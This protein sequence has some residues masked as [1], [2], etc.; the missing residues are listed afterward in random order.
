MV[1]GLCR[2]LLRNTDDAEDATQQVFV[3]AQR[4][5]LSG[6]VPREPPAWLAAIARNECRARIRSRMRE[7]LT[8]QELPNDLPDPLASALYADDLDAFWEAL[9][10]LPRRQRKAFL[11]RELGGLSYGELGVALGVTRPAVESLLFRARQGLRSFIAATNA[12]LI[13]VGLRDQLSRF[14]PE[15]GAA[16]GAGGVPLA[17]KVAAVTVGAGIGAAGVLELPKKAHHARPDQA[18]AP[19]V[20]HARQPA[21]ASSPSSS[22]AASSVAVKPRRARDTSAAKGSKLALDAEH[23]ARR[24]HGKGRRGNAEHVQETSFPASAPPGQWHSQSSNSSGKHLGWAKTKHAGGASDTGAAPGNSGGDAG[25]N[26]NGNGR[27]HG[28]GSD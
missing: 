23:V 4:A 28:N 1:L 12:A 17:A 19:R 9:S 8:T 14:L 16:A 22:A 3:S 6:A 5:V 13:P 26:G 21:V 27:G 10:Q 20:V 2:L 7:P 18:V 24:G 11:L 15:F 25:S